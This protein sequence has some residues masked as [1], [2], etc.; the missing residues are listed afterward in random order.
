MKEILTHWYKIDWSLDTILYT[1][2]ENEYTASIHSIIWTSEHWFF[3]FK[4]EIKDVIRKI[5]QLEKCI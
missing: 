5:R 3:K 4:W 2:W 1:V